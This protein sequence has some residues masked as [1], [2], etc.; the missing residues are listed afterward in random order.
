MDSIRAKSRGSFASIMRSMIAK[1]RSCR[2]RASLST[3]ST[4]D[5]AAS[6]IP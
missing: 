1:L 3:A 2:A 6:S 5:G 4:S